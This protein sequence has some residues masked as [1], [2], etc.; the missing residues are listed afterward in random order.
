RAAA[1]YDYAVVGRQLR[2]V[3]EKAIER[4]SASAPSTR[5]QQWLRRLR[6]VRRQAAAVRSHPS[7]QGRQL[8]QWWS[9]L[10]YEAASSVG[11]S[12]TIRFAGSSRV[13]SR[14]RGDSSSRVAFARWPDWP[15]M[16][17]WSTWLRPGDVFVDI[18][19]NVGLYSL[20]AAEQGAQVIA[21]E[22]ATDMA[23][24][25]EEN[26]Q[27][28]G[29]SDWVLHRAALLDREGWADLAGPDP[30]RRRVVVGD[31]GR[32]RV[33]APS[34][35]AVRVLTLDDAIGG[36]AVRGM[37]IDVE[38]VERLVLLG[39]AEVLRSSSL[40]LV[41]L[42][43]NDTSLAALGET[44]TPLAE[45]LVGV[46]FSLFQ[47]PTGSERFVNFGTAA[48][49]VGRDVFAA[50]GQVRELFDRAPWLVSAPQPEATMGRATRGD[51]RRSGWGRS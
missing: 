1:R 13:R 22:P 5:R 29:L 48:P 33:V 45:L 39:G 3:Y 44:R 10:R 43:W 11:R 46:G 8:Q 35:T 18:G 50:R 49:P 2:D 34:D 6:A 51:G 31:T 36:T 15:E 41:Q 30:N 25:F 20:V 38:G 40:E 19:A 7:N 16:R 23:D 28:N 4:R 27:L 14:K 9:I 26:M 17:V 32:Q 37:K 21:F 42:E 47:C 12:A 24:A